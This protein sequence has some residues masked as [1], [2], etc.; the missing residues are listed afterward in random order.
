M[1]IL[2]LTNFYPPEVRSISTMMRELAEGLAERGHEVTVFTS[3]PKENVSPD[4][5]PEQFSAD[6]WE[7]KVRVIRIKVP[8]SYSCNYVLRGLAQLAMPYFFWRAVRRLK[9]PTIDSVIVYTPHL[10]L[11][12]VGERIKKKYGARYLLNVQDIFPQNAIDL[13]IMHNKLLINFFEWM[14][15]RAYQAADAITTHTEGGRQFLITR[16]G[17]APEKIAVVANWIDVKP[18][19]EAKATGRFRKQYGLADEFVILF[20]GILGPAQNLDFVVEVAR[21]LTEVPKLIFLLVGEGTEKSRLEAL[22]SSY[23]LTNVRFA[24]FVSPSEYPF[25]LKEVQAGLMCL[26]NKNTTAAV[27]GKLFGFM[28]SGLPV[29]AFLN[30]ESDGYRIV[31]EA[32]CGFALVSDD[33]GKAVSLLRQIFEE[34]MDLAERGLHGQRYAAEHF[35]REIAIARLEGLASGK[36]GGK[37]ALTGTD[38]RYRI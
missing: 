20:A 32:N 25:L 30:R 5:R 8:S 26:G 10:P 1:R 23:G 3:W 15:A 38:M 34:Q 29:I 16:K 17:V 13:G 24:P 14:E 11:T 7:G 18:F 35:S 9:Y 36:T 22:V 12:L 33:V 4:A 28:A 27:P 19:A 31:K 37:T 21:Q 2:L 6:V